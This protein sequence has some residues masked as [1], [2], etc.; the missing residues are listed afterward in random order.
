VREDVAVLARNEGKI[1]AYEISFDVKEWTT[2]T[3]HLRKSGQFVFGY[4]HIGDGNIHINIVTEDNNMQ[5]HDEQIFKEVTRR[6][7]SISAEHG[8]GLHKPQY[9]H[10]QKSPQALGLL[11]SIKNLF[12]PQ[13]IM[14]PYKVIPE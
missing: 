8:V 1:L 4:G 3:N 10:L 7:G 11:K 9:L 6:Q 12:D 2:L 5:W 14:N 13:G